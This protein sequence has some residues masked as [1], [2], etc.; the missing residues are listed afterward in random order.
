MSEQFDE[1]AYYKELYEKEVEFADRLNNRTSNSLTILTII[2]SGHVLLISDIYPLEEP[3]KDFGLIVTLLCLASGLLF[4]R[5][6]YCF[7]KAYRGFG[8]E[9]YPTKEMAKSVDAAIRNPALQE[10]L[11]KAMTDLY[12]SGAITN[13]N[14]NR[15]KSAKQYEL[16]GAMARS[17]VALLVLFVIWFV[18]LKP[19]V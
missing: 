18:T 11:K 5:A 7:W 17:F 19:L 15:D 3:L 16:G 2:G 6:M 14:M 8:Y 13:R 9:Y 10:K 12:K 4:T 1:L